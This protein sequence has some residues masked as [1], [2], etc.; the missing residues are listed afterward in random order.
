M[1]LRVTDDDGAVGPVDT[2]QVTVENLPPTADSGG[3][4][5]ATVDTPL[6]L[7]GSGSDVPQDTLTVDW[8][9]DNDTIFE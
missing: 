8:D 3:P 6:A 4:Y 5:V 9:L 2:A 1:A 7:N